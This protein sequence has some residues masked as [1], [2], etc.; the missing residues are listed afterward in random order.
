MAALGLAFCGIGL[1]VASSN[2]SAVASSAPGAPSNITVTRQA[3]QKTL[4][5]NWTAGTNATGYHVV[6]S[7]TYKHSWALI[8][9]DH[10]ATNIAWTP[11]GNDADSKTFFVAVRSKNGNQYSH[12]V[13]AGPFAPT[14]IVAPG[15][16]VLST[17]G[18]DDG[19]ITVSWNKSS[20]SAVTYHVVYS[21]N[22][23]ASWSAF[24]SHYQNKP[25]DC[26]EAQAGD[27]YAKYSCFTL[28]GLDNSKTYHIAVR[29]LFNGQWG[30]W[31]NSDA[32]HPVAQLRIGGGQTACSGT[33]QYALRLA[34]STRNAS[35][36]QEIQYR[37]DGGQWVTHNDATA[38]EFNKVQPVG[39]VTKIRWIN[40][41]DILP[42]ANSAYTVDVKMRAKKTINN[43]VLYSPWAS[44][45][46]KAGTS[47][48][49]TQSLL[50]CPTTP[51]GL[52]ATKSTNSIDISWT[53]DTDY[54]TTHDIIYSTDS[55]ATW[56][57]SH[58]GLDANSAKILEAATPNNP[59]EV[60]DV[61]SVTNIKV[62]ARNWDGN[63]STD[64]VEITS[65]SFQ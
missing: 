44:I 46:V 20:N 16:P 24:G 47:S 30:Q 5:I 65:A 57:Y 34:W 51:T 50:R 52:S 26:T 43:S 35:H 29:T 49:T 58:I 37:V 60:S 55:G 39:L 61:D 56:R 10:A 13:N 25:V 12:W 33:Q 31:Y 1:M 28:T 59:N 62:R 11:P 18:R 40:I 42:V 22:G 45:S 9:L 6:A 4:N 15:K 38:P 14:G 21:D 53:S 63:S 3:N 17:N 19:S 48:N 54:T 64:W 27:Q 2:N 36:D 32:I 8:S 23:K 7:S 41:F